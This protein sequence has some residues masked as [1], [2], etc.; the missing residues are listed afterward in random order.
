MPKDMLLS[1]LML[2]VS[3]PNTT[4]PSCLYYSP[5]I[6]ILV[7]IS[8]SHSPALHINMPFLSSQ[9]FPTIPRHRHCPVGHQPHRHCYSLSN[10]SMLTDGS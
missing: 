1:L 4:L 7:S 3:V 9:D 6:H 8:L 2:D 5:P 10:L